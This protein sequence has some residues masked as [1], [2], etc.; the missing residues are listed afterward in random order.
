[1]RARSWLGVIIG[2]SG[3][4]GNNVQGNYIGT[5]KDGTGD[6]G[7]SDWGVIIGSGASDNQV[8]GASRAAA[9]I[10]AFNGETNQ[11]GVGINDDDS[12]G[13]RILGNSIFSNADLGIDLEH[14]GPTDNDPGD[15]GA[16]SLQN[17]PLLT[18]ASDASFFYSIL[19]EF[20]GTSVSER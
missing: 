19:L 6:L 14:D 18:S 8:G 2:G 15:T 16:N 11:D 4:T 7:N 12:T 5:T 3:S 9:N 13:N 10:I 17:F 20:G 1:M